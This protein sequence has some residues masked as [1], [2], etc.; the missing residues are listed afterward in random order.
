MEKAVA[1]GASSSAKRGP[2]RCGSPHFRAAGNCKVAAL[3][4][5]LVALVGLT[6]LDAVLLEFSKGSE[7]PVRSSGMGDNLP[8]DSVRAVGCRLRKEWPSASAP[9]SGAGCTSRCLSCGLPWLLCHSMPTINAAITDDQHL[10]RL[11]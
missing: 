11:M 10:N 3:A 4:T 5:R 2:E 9:A 1:S 8:L 6:L 7:S